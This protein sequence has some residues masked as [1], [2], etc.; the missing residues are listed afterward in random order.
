MKKRNILGLATFLGAIFY[1]ADTQ[2]N[3]SGM[4]PKRD[5]RENICELPLEQ[6]LSIEE[7]TKRLNDMHSYAMTPQ[8]LVFI[9]RVT[10]M[11]AGNDPKA[12]TQEDLQR[13]WEGVAQVILN[14]YLFDKNHNTHLFGKNTSMRGIA[15]A[16]MQF[17]PVSFFPELF[18]DKS[19]TNKEGEAV[20]N[21]GRIPAKKVA[22]VYDTVLSV[23]ERKKEDITDEAVFFLA[24]YIKK[25]RRDGTRP[26]SVRK[27]PCYTRSTLQINTHKFF[28]TSCPIDPYAVSMQD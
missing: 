8:D 28:A 18:K 12:K 15:E 4:I 7:Q 23:L 25:G 22:Q 26:F 1:T 14:R 21:Y 2:S 27:E 3:F 19:L 5:Q 17:H 10:Y 20:L 6:R 11:E 9:T 24:D 13:G 16:N